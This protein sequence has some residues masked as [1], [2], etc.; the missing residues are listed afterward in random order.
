MNELDLSWI[1]WTTEDIKRVPEL[2]FAPRKDALEK[3]KRIP[4]GERT[5]E[6]TILGIENTYNNQ[7]FINYLEALRNVS[8]SKEVRD[9]V[10]DVQ[11]VIQK[12]F[13]DLYFDDD[14]W[15]SIEE[16]RERREALNGPNK[17]LFEEMQR[18]FR[19][20]GFGKSKEIR[21]RVKEISKRL[22]EFSLTFSK[23]INEYRDQIEVK[24]EELKG[25]DEGFINGL[26]KNEQGG[27]IIGLDYPEYYP[28]M[29]HAENAAKRKELMDKNLQKGGMGNIEVLI[30]VLRLR[31]EKAEFLGYKNHV[32][33]AAEDLMTKTEETVNNFLENLG[34]KIKVSATKDLGE[35][36]DLKKRLVGDVSAKVEYFDVSYLSEKLQKEK[37]NFDSEELRKYFPLSKVR[38]GIFKIYSELFSVRFEPVKEKLWHEDVELYRILDENSNVMAFFALDIFP[39]EGKYTHA[40]CMN[41]FDSREE[42]GKRLIPFGALVMNFRKPN[43]NVPSLLSHGEVETFFH[44]FGHLMHFCLSKP[45]HISQSSFEVAWD[46]V[47]APSQML[48]YWVWNKET[49]PLLSEHYETKQPIPGDIL[50]SLVR[51]KDFFMGYFTATQLTYAIFDNRLHRLYPQ[52]D[53]GICELF[54]KL[55]KEYTKVDFP[56]GS[57]FPAGFG[58]LMGYDAKYYGYTWSRVFAADMFTRFEKEGIL[59]GKTGMDYRK[60]IL[61]PGASKEET[62]MVREFLGREPS[63]KAFIKEIGIE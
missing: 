34:E 18:D 30:E 54:L 5:F 25:M 24:P 37:F 9:A 29:G 53:D 33:F 26:R 32:A 63:N 61:E 44:E 49:L 13:L 51:S 11:Q 52:S 46:F 8:V 14:V 55:K 4:R 41:I 48:E 50:D 20:M 28:F 56:K 45:K 10:K 39:R 59:N 17:K 35:L 15:R 3:I 58:H 42:G 19:R 57:R 12:E 43:G 27:Y 47:E 38:E 7:H 2:L 62:D 31:K 36:T 21:D 16:Y 6:N 23:N 40:M 1:G 22:F 60:F